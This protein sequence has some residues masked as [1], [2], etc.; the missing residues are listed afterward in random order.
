MSA[1]ETTTI[2]KEAAGFLFSFHKYG[3]PGVV[4]AILFAFNGGLTFYLIKT[5][6][7][8]THAMTEM[9]E[10]ARALKEA[11]AN[12]QGDEK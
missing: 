7:Q 3:L 11:V 4:I 10:A 6:G 5:V 8:S 2:P 9:A 12:C 1:T